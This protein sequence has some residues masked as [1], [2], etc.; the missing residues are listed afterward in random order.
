VVGCAN[1]NAANALSGRRA[2]H[3]LVLGA[4]RAS[5]LGL[6]ASTFSDAAQMLLR[7]SADPTLCDGRGLTAR[8][9][10]QLRR[11]KTNDYAVRHAL[12]AVLRA[13]AQHQVR[14]PLC[15]FWRPF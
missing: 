8:A 5:K 11:R 1:P 9:F 14:R 2:L 15:P 7:A 13:L 4:S 10:A 6:P 3:A 12:A